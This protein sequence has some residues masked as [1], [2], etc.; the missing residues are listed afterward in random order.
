MNVTVIPEVMPQPQTESVHAAISAS[1]PA[2]SS[3]SNRTLRIWLE[4]NDHCSDTHSTP[5]LQ[6]G[7]HD[8]PCRC[9]S[10]ILEE[11]EDIQVTMSQYA[12]VLV[13]SSYLHETNIVKVALFR[14]EGMTA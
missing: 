10:S 9:Q 1:Q 4:S 12:R 5:Q 7:L 14:R 6:S 13:Q 3:K 2:R 11:L 8:G